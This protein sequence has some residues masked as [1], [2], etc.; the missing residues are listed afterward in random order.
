MSEVQ[1]WTRVLGVLEPT[2]LCFRYT[3]GT[4]QAVSGWLQPQI[5]T[6]GA[7]RRPHC[8]W[9]GAQDLDIPVQLDK[10]DPDACSSRPSRSEVMQDRLSFVSLCWTC[11]RMTRRRKQGKKTKCSRAQGDTEG[12]IQDVACSFLCDLPHAFPVVSMRA[13]LL[14]YGPL[15]PFGKPSTFKG[16]FFHPKGCRL[17]RAAN[18]TQVWPAEWNHY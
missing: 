11:R 13:V 18:V 7:T 6:T 1:N 9:N 17:I 5:T 4:A 10:R 16:L 15:S 8:Y 3:T 12:R 2:P 14:C